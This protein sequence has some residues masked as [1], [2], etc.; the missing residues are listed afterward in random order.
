MSLAIWREVIR[1]AVA[2][3]QP[4]SFGDP[5]RITEWA[6]L[7]VEAHDRA[8]G[9][10]SLE[11]GTWRGATAFVFCRLLER[12]YPPETRPMLFTVDPY[13]DK[14]YNGGDGPERPALYG[15]SDYVIM[16]KLLAR[17]PHHAH[18][19]MTSE[20]FFARRETPYWWNGQPHEVDRV[21]FALIDG[22]H[23][24]DSIRD[25][26]A[27]VDRVLA[28]DGTIVADNVD[29]DQR[30]L[31]AEAVPAGYVGVEVTAALTSHHGLP[32]QYLILRR[33]AAEVA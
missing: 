31:S 18:F 21:T 16:K 17:F 30:L 5:Q 15:N 13:G 25:D 26:I 28:P 12:L 7:F 1:A 2:E 23:D 29:N 8:P 22:E 9:G 24:A 27:D 32:Q 19:Y 4:Y 14:P 6:E 11:I 33:A 20:A 10:L 3:A